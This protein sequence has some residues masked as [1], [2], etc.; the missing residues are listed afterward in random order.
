MKKGIK[1]LLLGLLLL[2]T[3]GCSLHSPEELYTLPE[4]P[5]EY[6]SLDRR[7][8][9]TMSALGAEYAAPLTGNNIQTVQLQDIDGDGVEEAIAFFR[10]T[11]DA[12]PLKVY[13]FKQGSDNT[14]DTYAVIEGEGTAIYSINYENL[15]GSG[16]AEVVVSWRMSEKVHSLA[17]Y[18]VTANSV[19]ELMRTGYTRYKLIDIDMDNRQEIIVLQVDAA[20]GKSRAELYDYR[21]DG[22]VLCATAPMSYEIKE[23]SAIKAGYLRDSVPTLL[24]SSTFG[25]NNGLLTDIFA[26]RNGTLENIT[27]DPSTGQSVGTMRYY[28]MVS[29]TDIN[30]DSILEVPLPVALPTYQKVTAASDF[31][32][33]H[34]RQYDIEGNA[35]PVCTTYHNVQDR[36]YLV[37][38]QAWE[39]K[40]TLTRKDNT[41]NG[42]RAVVFSRWMG[43]DVDPTPFLTIYRLTGANREIRSRIGNRF[44]LMTESDT[45]YAAEFHDN[46]WDCGLG[47]EELMENFNLIQTEWST[48]N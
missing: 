19:T 8:Q 28:N 21:E 48:E 43:E 7:I 45:I 47:Q 16:A 32:A 14:Y 40:L 33:I 5:A 1:L 30:R 44:V 37:L 6:K 11:G 2:M 42:E 41:V 35:W 17:A 3:A 46:Q 29:S 31:W 25:E 4:P 22:L 34:W 9:E 24:V 15:G 39:G 10:V 23:I 26:W 18:A 38:P 13:I 36:W 20:E 27:I 12:K